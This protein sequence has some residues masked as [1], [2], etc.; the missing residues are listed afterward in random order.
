M[1]IIKF[2]PRILAV[3]VAF[4]L[5]LTQSAF[6]PTLTPNYGK[7]ATDN[8]HLIGSRTMVSPSVEPGANEYRCLLN[9]EKIC[10]AEFDYSSPSNA[11]ND[12]LPGSESPGVYDFG[13]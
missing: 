7:D 8:W 5:I 3:A 9:E 2:N 12:Y 11:A 6:R 10:T 4:A 13:N 1:N